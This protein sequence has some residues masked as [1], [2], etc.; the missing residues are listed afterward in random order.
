MRHKIIPLILAAFASIA[1]PACEDDTTIINPDPG[2]PST[3]PDASA[4]SKAT[5]SS[6]YAPGNNIILF[7]IG[8]SSDETLDPSNRGRTD[9]VKIVLPKALDE[10]ITI[11]IYTPDK[12]TIA[13]Y[14]SEYGK[15]GAGYK[16]EWP[17]NILN[18]ISIDGDTEK[19]ITIKAG[20]TESEEFPINF[21]RKGI[22][23]GV[24]YLF[25]IELADVSTGEIYS[26]TDYF[27]TPIR[28][29]S[30]IFGTKPAVIIGYIDTEVVSP[31]IADKFNYELAKE[32]FMTGDHDVIYCGPL[33]DIIN[34]RTASVGVD[35]QGAPIV[36][37]TADLE[38]ILKNRAKYLAP[39]QKDGLKICL[40][41]KG[42][43]TGLGF[44]NMTD[45]QISKFVS[46]AKVLVDMYSLDGI[47]L[48]DKNSGYDIDGAAEVNP[49]SYAKLIK[50]LKTAMP[51][52]LLTL[53]DTRETTE[54][55][56]DPVAGISVG[57][58]L[59]Y[60]WSDL[61]ELT[62]AYGPD[63]DHRPLSG[64]EEKRYGTIFMR[65]IAMMPEEAQMKLMEHPVISE[66]QMMMRTTPMS[67]TDVLVFYDIPYHD[68][69]HEGCWTQNTF[70]W[71]AARYPIPE[72]FS[73]ITTGQVT[74]PGYMNHI[75]FTFKKDW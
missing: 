2:H 7:N 28:N 24:S 34:I 20:H 40:C 47:N 63:A 67:G 69:A 54:A 72:D 22:P 8:S 73:Y 36:S 49:E 11:R 38:Y 52:K 61:E 65:D 12:E 15:N 1:L 41:I 66:Y 31:L 10:D 59:D 17:D 5:L 33:Y 27:V 48:W 42:G 43:N 21:L 30:D 60:A 58:Y 51:D 64:I 46:R 16:L 62:F 39:M 3:A 13:E 70:I 45:A 32:D 71:E 50:A 26:R 53:V 6:A 35:A 9:Q 37:L 14:V 74:I 75:Y 29:N 25:P 55:L 68:Y 19:V 57:D 18:N 44:A 23:D 4:T 56:C